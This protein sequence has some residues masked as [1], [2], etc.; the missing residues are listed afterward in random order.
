MTLQEFLDLPERKPAL[1]F[2][3]GVVTRKVSPKA[4]HSILQGTLVQRINRHA[5]A[6][7][8]ALAFP[9]LRT[10]FGGYSLV[11]DV[12]VYLWERI[13]T[14]PTGEAEDDVREPPDI[15]VEIVSPRQTVNQL[16]RRCVWYVDNGVRVALLVDPD[17]RSVIVFRPDS[18]TTALRG[19][20]AVDLSDVIP[21]FQLVVDDLFA[22]LRIREAG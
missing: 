11:P 17:D 9:E 5:E 3:D 12:A 13:P 14:D 22:S 7:K 1:E 2:E 16:V 8:M 21:G 15:A 20:E 4:R 6:Q 19:N 10:T 18:R